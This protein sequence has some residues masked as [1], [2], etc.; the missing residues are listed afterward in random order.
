MPSTSRSRRSIVTPFRRGPKRL[1]ACRIAVSEPVDTGVVALERLELAADDQLD[2]PLLG[3]PVAVDG[4]D[5][6]AVAQHGDA[7]GEAEHLGGAVADEQDALAA[8]GEDA[9]RAEQRLD[10]GLR[11]RGGR[12][13]EDEDAARVLVLVLERAGDGDHRAL[14]R[15]EVQEQVGRAHVDVV[16]IEDLLRSTAQEA[17]AD[18]PTDHGS[19]SRARSR[20]SRPR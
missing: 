3:E 4:G 16:A 5:L 12:L 11:Q 1:R 9:Q 7:G 8:A 6:L 20:C 17:L 13:V 2:D 10:L 19:G 14:G 15:T 18:A